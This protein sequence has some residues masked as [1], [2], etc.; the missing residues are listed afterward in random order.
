MKF[1]LSAKPDR[2]VAEW[3]QDQYV[4]TFGLLVTPRF[5]TK[6]DIERAN[7]LGAVWAADNDCYQGLDRERFILMLNMVS[8]FPGCLFVNAPDVVGDAAST[9]R[10]FRLWQ[11]VIRYFGLPAALV[12]Q[13]GLED[14]SVPWDDFET[15]F[16][17][18]SAG[19]KESDHARVLAL[20]AKRR[21]KYVHV[22]RVNSTRRLKMAL[23]M[24]AD[25]IDGT[26]M[27]KFSREKLP[28]LLKQERNH[29]FT[30]F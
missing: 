3:G 30:H 10:R 14:L 16:I 7:A 17:G 26:G 21:G 20:E 1:I 2:L 4:E 9:L 11:P 29:H 5:G 22:G 6:D 8:A 18:G 27:V 24:R 28:R 15:L 23:N 19:W 13:D 25:S 12:A